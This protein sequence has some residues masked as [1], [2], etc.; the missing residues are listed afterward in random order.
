MRFQLPPNALVYYVA[1][2]PGNNYYY[3]ERSKY[4]DYKKLDF[5][6]ERYADYLNVKVFLPE[7]LAPQSSI[8]IFIL[9]KV[10]ELAKKDFLGNF[11]FE[12]KTAIDVD[13]ILTE[14]VRVAVNVQPGFSL[15]GAKSEVNYQ[16]DFFS[17]VTA[18]QFMVM[19]EKPYGYYDSYYNIEYTQGLVKEAY[20]LDQ[21][22]SF[23]VR[24][25]YSDNGIALYLPEILIGILVLAIIFGATFFA[26]KRFAKRPSQPKTKGKEEE[27]QQQSIKELIGEAYKSAFVA[28]IVTSLAV[29]VLV[30]ITSYATGLLMGALSRSQLVDY[31]YTGLLMII[32]MLIAASVII[33]ELALP[34]HFVYKK[35]SLIAGIATFLLALVFL[36][37]LVL[38][39]GIM[40]KPMTQIYYGLS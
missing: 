11:N 14:K 27:Q 1:Q 34:A 36:F 31:S 26:I 38:L 15:K 30:I 29:A 12:F 2:G 7:E 23:T 17:E 16:K 28:V 13:A 9:Y 25:S 19:V 4:Y 33:L 3:Y 39:I 18:T 35:H 5:N 21:Y 10:P 32:L 40:M 37:I 22:E 8:G 6:K 20:S 24:G